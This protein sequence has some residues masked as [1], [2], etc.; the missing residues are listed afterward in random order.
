MANPHDASEAASRLLRPRRASKLPR[1]RRRAPT[2]APAWT[3]AALFLTGCPHVGE[4]SEAH[5]HLLRGHDDLGRRGLRLLVDADRRRQRRRL[6]HLLLHQRDRARLA[7][8]PAPAAAAVS[9]AVPLGRVLLERVP[10]VGRLQLAGWLL[11]ARQRRGEHRAALA[12][13][14]L[15]PHQV[16]EDEVVLRVVGTRAHQVGRVVHRRLRPLQRHA[17]EDL[18]LARRV[19]DAQRRVCR[20]AS[21]VGVRAERS[22]ADA[23]A[24][25]LLEARHARDE[26]RAHRSVSGVVRG[27]LCVGC[28]SCSARSGLAGPNKHS[29]A[30]PT[31]RRRFC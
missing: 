30:K 13:K 5:V 21:I 1:R 23:L 14:L 25:L 27:L 28:C 20:V 16:R 2:H 9:I 7:L 18:R 19:D 26:R 6:A 3:E 4:L 12:R 8:G 17:H 24:L 10:D 22:S 11:E 31:P 29:G 15:E